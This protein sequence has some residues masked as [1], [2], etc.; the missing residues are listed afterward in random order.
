VRDK[1]RTINEALKLMRGGCVLQQT[2]TKTGPKWF[3]VPD[4]GEVTPNVAA[5]LLRR[6][7]VRSQSAGL[8]PGISQSY[9]I[10][11]GR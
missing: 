8:F 1:I 11:A 10:T 7:D 3:V 2:H 4:G 6:K 9:E 5:D